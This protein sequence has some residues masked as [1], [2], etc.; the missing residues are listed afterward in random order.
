MGCL[1]GQSFSYYNYFRYLF[2][3]RRFGRNLNNYF[4]DNYLNVFFRSTY[5][6]SLTNNLNPFPCTFINSTDGSSFKYF[7]NLAIYTS[8]LLPLK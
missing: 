5:L 6:R 1:N 3:N 8:M 4:L 2:I 7:R